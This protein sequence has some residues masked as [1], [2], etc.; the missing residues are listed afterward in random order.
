[1]YSYDEKKANSFTNKIASS[2]NYLE[3][4]A[5]ILPNFRHILEGNEKREITRILYTYPNKLLYFMLKDIDTNRD[6]IIADILKKEPRTRKGLLI[7]KDIIKKEL[8]N[9]SIGYILSIYDFISS[10]ASNDKTIGD[11]ERFDFSKNTNYRLQNLLMQENVGHFNQFFERAE[12]LY[13]EKKILPITK[14]MV[15]LIVRKYFLHHEVELHGDSM[16]IID[17]FFGKDQ[18]KHIQMIQAKNQIIKK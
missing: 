2:I 5:K 11:L 14:Q 9:Q 1:L 3:L 13:D 12:A 4:V 18:R 6:R 15:H 7:T 16:R 17:K 8:Q 10:T